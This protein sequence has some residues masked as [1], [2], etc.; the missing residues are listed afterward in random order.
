MTDLTTGSPT[1]QMLKFAMP[2]C[3]GNL[4]QLF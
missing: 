1:K 4:F 3:L 2:V